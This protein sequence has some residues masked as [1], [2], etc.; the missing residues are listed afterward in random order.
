MNDRTRLELVAVPLRWATDMVVDALSRYGRSLPPDVEHE[1]R[2]AC[3]AL[4]QAR[5]VLRDNLRKPPVS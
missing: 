2:E 5:D 3:R 4:Q 1:L